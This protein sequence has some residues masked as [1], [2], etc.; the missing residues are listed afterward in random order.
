MID[1]ARRLAALLA[2]LAAVTILTFLMTSLLPGDP[3]V[4]LLGTSGASESAVRQVR[5]QLGLNYPI[6]VQYLHWL[7]HLLH[8]NLGYSYAASTSVNSELAVCL[9]V[10]VE[11]V[12]L[13][14]VISLAV[15]IPLGTIT[16]YLRGKL[17]DNIITST[18]FT[19]LAVP[20]F[21]LAL[22]LILVFAV[23][24]RWSPASGWVNF[25][26]NPVQNLQHAILPSVALALPQVA[27]FSRLLRGDMISTLREDYVRLAEAKGLT[28]RR[29]LF[30]HAF[31]PSSFSLVT[32]VGLQVGFLLGGTVVIENLF[33][34]PGIG[35]L[36]IQ[37]I[38]TRDLI[39]VQAI[40][41]VIACTFVLVNALVDALYQVLDPRIRIASSHA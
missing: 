15:A 25:S 33:A 14:M 23:G 7:E 31:R 16:A 2:T 26:V 41:L 19:L 18:T 21:V 1:L 27:I 6:P 36:L 11:I 20:N 9:P 34:L 13:A 40:T 32:V 3:A 4:A 37:S 22:L 35:S 5:Q 24:L 17:F 12:V 29:I 30:M 39:T 28:V 8:G 10:T 38:N